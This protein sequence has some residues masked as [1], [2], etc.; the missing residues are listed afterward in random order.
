MLCLIKKWVMRMKI[1]KI[2]VYPIDIKL[3]Q[4]F[5]TALG[6]A[7]TVKTVI[8]RVADDRGN[9]GWG[10]AVP[11]ERISGETTESAISAIGLIATRILGQDPRRIERIVQLMDEV[12]YG[13]T[14]AKAGIDIAIHD[15]VGRTWGEPLWR[16][17]GGYRAEQI[18]TD[19][20]IGI[21]DLE[22]T[23]TEARN[24]VSKGFKALKVKVGAEPNSDI[25]KI[26][27]IREAVGEGIRL[28]V[29][30]NQGWTRQ[31]AIKALREMDQ[32]NIEFAEQPVAS[33][34]ISGLA[35]VRRFV[36]M[37]IM[38]DESVHQ[39]EDAIRVIQEEAVDYINIKLMKS[40]GFCK[41]RQI[42]AIA[43]AA[44]IGCMM[45]GMV[46]SDLAATAAV[47]L[48]VAVRNIK[49]RD[50]DMGI[51]LKKRVIADGG[52]ELQGQYRTVPDAPGLGI[53]QINE[54]LLGDPLRVYNIN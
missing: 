37:P 28:R 45:G 50:L 29:D 5:T 2:G 26:E 4:P 49:F 42:A 33:H 52:S 38:A 31:Q 18:D 24:L 36:P 44:G 34:D 19:F 6:M 25:H 9:I 12:I 40:G 54:D 27:R 15:L 17:L 53:L 47:H 20:T 7:E 46:E 10:E 16:L 1:S 51:S 11:R 3:T 21:Q 35:Q 48:A 39:P 43:E 32:Y 13:N 41:A 23:V 8:V 22:G 30:A 14:S